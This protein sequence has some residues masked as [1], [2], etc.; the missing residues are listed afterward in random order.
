MVSPYPLFGFRIRR[1]RG[2]FLAFSS[3]RAAVESVEPSSRTRISIESFFCREME[4]RHAPRAVPRC[5]REESPK[6]L[7]SC[8]AQSCC[9]PEYQI[10]FPCPVRIRRRNPRKKRGSASR[11]LY[12]NPFPGKNKHG[13][14]VWRGKPPFRH[15]KE[16]GQFPLY[17]FGTPALRSSATWLIRS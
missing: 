12:N 6:E 16:G 10:I 14:Q 7:F 2:S 1:I 8:I 3:A 15:G 9:S 17:H 11:F 4:S 5:G 13:I